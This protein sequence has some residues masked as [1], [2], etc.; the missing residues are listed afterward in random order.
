GAFDFRVSLVADE[1]AFAA[2]AAVAGHFHVHL[3]HQRTG[4]VEYLEATALGLLAHGLGY[5]MGAEDDDGIVGH[6]MQF[7]DEHRATRAQVF[8]HKL[9]VYHFMPHIDRRTKHFKG[10][11]DDLDGA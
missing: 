7:F 4:R 11:I 5:A 6:L 2:V 10:A 8:D 1:D 9:V 3:G